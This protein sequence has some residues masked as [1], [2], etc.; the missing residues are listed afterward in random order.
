MRILLRLRLDLG[1]VLSACFVIAVGCE[2]GESPPSD[3]VSLNPETVQAIV[4]RTGRELERADFFKP[5]R[6][7][8]DPFLFGLAPL[9]LEELGERGH[10]TPEARRFGRLRTGDDGALE[11]DRSKPT[12]YYQRSTTTLSGRDYERLSFVWCRR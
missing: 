10:Q 11:I 4:E 5:R 2:T 12:V 6:E 3:E 9:I 8:T 1:H 7:D